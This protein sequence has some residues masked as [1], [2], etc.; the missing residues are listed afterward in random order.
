MYYVHY[1][2]EKYNIVVLHASVKKGPG[3]HKLQ[4]LV[5]LTKG[6]E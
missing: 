4:I 1:D 5:K 2:F 3:G 6:G